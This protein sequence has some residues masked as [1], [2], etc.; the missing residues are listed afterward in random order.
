MTT[1]KQTCMIIGDPVSQSLSPALHNYLY[2][3]IGLADKFHFVAREI[4]ERDLSSCINDFRSGVRT[5]DWL[6]HAS[7]AN[8]YNAH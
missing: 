2:D 5:R 3:L 7:Q 8:Y 6:H 1:T 4:S